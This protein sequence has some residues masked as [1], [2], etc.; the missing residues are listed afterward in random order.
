MGWKKIIFLI[1][2]LIFAPT[3][4]VPKKHIKA[5]IR[6]FFRIG[7]NRQEVPNSRL[8]RFLFWRHYF[9]GA[10]VSQ[11]RFDG[12]R[13]SRKRA[14]TAERLRVAGFNGVRP[15]G[16]TIE[17][18]V[19]H[20]SS[21]HANSIPE[22]LGAPKLKCHFFAGRLIV[23]RVEC[24]PLPGKNRTQVYRRRSCAAWNQKGAK[25]VPGL[26]PSSSDEPY[27]TPP[28]TGTFHTRQLRRLLRLRLEELQGPPKTDGDGSRFLSWGVSVRERERSGLEQTLWAKIIW[29]HRRRRFCRRTARVY[30]G[31]PSAESSR[32]NDTK[33]KEW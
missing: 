20:S 14:I 17:A 8:Q 11:H 13:R 6:T 3:T 33:I 25:N 19:I 31:N 26:Y 27:L 21:K 4:F 12:S 28:F 23:P 16:A 24:V 2:I 7:T 9:R 15:A 30:L 29:N 10:W 18:S 22:M 5:L 32:L 1:P